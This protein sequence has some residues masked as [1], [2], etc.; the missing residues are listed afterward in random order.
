MGEQYIFTIE[1]LTKAY[2]K[3]EVLKDI[4]LSFY[5]GAKIG[6]HRLATGRARARCCGSWPA[7]TRTSSA[8]PGLTTGVTIGYVPQEP[9][10]DAEQDRAARTSRR[11][12]PP[13][14]AC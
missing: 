10:L 5:P 7:R 9:Q 13:S 4:W 14:A 6:V 11:P 2:G 8:R 1:N 3:K 12:S